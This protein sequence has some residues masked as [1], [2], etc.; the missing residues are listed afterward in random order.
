MGTPRKM[1]G[2]ESIQTQ[3]TNATT[4]QGLEDRG[5]H[6]TKTHH[7]RLPLF[8]VYYKIFVTAHEESSGDHLDDMR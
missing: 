8:H 7:H 1:T 4:R 6:S 2:P 5:A 3:W